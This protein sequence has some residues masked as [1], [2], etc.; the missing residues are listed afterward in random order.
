MLRFDRTP[1]RFISSPQRRKTAPAKLKYATGLVAVI[2]LAYSLTT[3]DALAITVEVA[4]KCTELAA[5][6]YPPRVPGNPAAGYANGTAEDYRK[7]INK[8]VAN[9][10]NVDQAPESDKEALPAGSDK[11]GQAPK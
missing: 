1:R 5:K 10:G 11:D 7:Y 4:K 3:R 2:C 9:G 6:A 8:C